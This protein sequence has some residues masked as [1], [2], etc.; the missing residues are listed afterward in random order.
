M[1]C[2]CFS[3]SKINF[4]FIEENHLSH[5]FLNL[6]VFSYVAMTNLCPIF[7]MFISDK[8]IFILFYI[9]LQKIF[10]FFSCI[11]HKYVCNKKKITNMCS[12]FVF[13]L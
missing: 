13:F 1:I 4:L 2:Y 5:V 9:C 11:D 7:F 6:F 12:L 8:Y 3:I 10:A